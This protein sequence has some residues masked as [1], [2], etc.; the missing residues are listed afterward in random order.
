MDHVTVYGEPGVYAGW[1][2]N[3]GHWQWG[4]EFLVGFLR[5]RWCSYGMHHI[6]QPFQKMLARSLDAGRTWK[7]ETPNVDFEAESVSTLGLPRIAPEETT[8][9]FCGRYDI[10]GEYCAQPGGVYISSNK[11]HRW[12]GPFAFNT[13]LLKDTVH[14]T[15]RTCALGDLIF[16]SYALQ[17]H[18]GTD[19]VECHQWTES[20]EDWGFQPKSVVLNDNARAVMPAAAKIYL[21]TGILQGVAGVGGGYVADTH[22]ER[23]VVTMRR[24]GNRYQGK[25]ECWIDSMV[26]DDGG[27]TW[28]GPYHVADT[29]GYNG[30]PPALS[31]LGGKL[32]CAH[33][34][35]DA[36]A[37][38]L[39]E[40]L[41]G[42]D[43]KQ[44]AIL[45]KG[46]CRDIGYPRL[47]AHE[48][49]LTCVYYWSN[50]GEEQR[51]EATRYKVA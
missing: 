47:F 17:D 31:A 45:R 50:E 44:V 8:F 34:N 20:E 14:C 10:G 5:G 22:K 48:D 40:S 32:Y 19:W 51:I 6:Q 43:W 23:I 46:D 49:T 33:G 3:H 12:H 9:R 21:P 11:G 18:W 35:R 2:A 16:V 24:R 39:W 26:S 7:I 13:T 27:Q 29:G 36:R 25:F 1:P 4:N 30:N 38:W 28:E 41:D 37:I 15:T 42:I